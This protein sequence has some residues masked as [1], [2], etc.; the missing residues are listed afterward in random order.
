MGVEQCRDQGED[1]EA[2]EQ[3][4]VGE[5]NQWREEDET[6][7]KSEGGAGRGQARA[8]DRIDRGVCL[9]GIPRK[10]GIGLRAR[11]VD[12]SG[13]VSQGCPRRQGMLP[14]M[15]SSKTSTSSASFAMR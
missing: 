8:S 10:R 3:Q 9:D 2:D 12:R 5:K 6:P 15:A 14:S 1:E 13:S 4:A 11:A 7:S